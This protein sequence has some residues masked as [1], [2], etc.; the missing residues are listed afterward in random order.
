MIV[1]TMSGNISV[2]DNNGYQSLVRV[3]GGNIEAVSVGS[4]AVMYLNEEGKLQGLDVNHIATA[5][6]R[7]AIDTLDIIVG[8]VCI[9]GNDGGEN[10][11]DVPL[12]YLD[13]AKKIKDSSDVL[14]NILK[15]FD[16]NKRT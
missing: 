2:Q 7:D 16:K 10:D 4:D 13:K 15:L 12:S 1:I 6:Y 14:Q 8:N 5:L 11:V 3:V 9:V